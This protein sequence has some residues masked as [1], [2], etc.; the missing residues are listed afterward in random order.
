MPF[1]SVLIGVATVEIE[2]LI[3]YEFSDKENLII[4][5]YLFEKEKKCEENLPSIVTQM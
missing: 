5:L 1:S 4:S 3:A 2:H